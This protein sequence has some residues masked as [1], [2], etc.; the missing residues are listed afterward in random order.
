VVKSQKRIE[1][2]ERTPEKVQ[3]S[4]RLWQSGSAGGT[5]K[6]YNPQERHTQHTLHTVKNKETP[7]WPNKNKS[8]PF[9]FQ[10]KGDI[11]EIC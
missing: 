4:K 2:V 3:S 5:N 8:P 10:V 1:K 7:T 11:P 9:S 6:T